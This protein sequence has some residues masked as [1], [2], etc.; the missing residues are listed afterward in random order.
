MYTEG[1]KIGDNSYI[2]S[3]EPLTILTS[4]A[5]QEAIEEY[6]NLKNTY[7]EEIDEYGELQDDL[8]KI[9]NKDRNS[10]KANIEIFL[11]TVLIE[12]L[13]IFIIALENMELI[14]AL[15]LL[16]FPILTSLMVGVIFKPIIY[17]TKKKRTKKKE[18]LRTSL[19]KKNE[20][21]RNIEKKMNK[22]KE[23]IEKETYLFEDEIIPVTTTEK[24]KS[25]IK[26][27][28]LKLDPNRYGSR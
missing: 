4:K 1:F 3:E 24:T 19:S 16:S 5:S 11:S 15:Q 12:G 6:I 13:F 25:N 28:V 21:I 7:E 22:I 10:K 17:G 23:K 26:I 20:E 2:L 27:R 9:N 18:A 8:S 14:P